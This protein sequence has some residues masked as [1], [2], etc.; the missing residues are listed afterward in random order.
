MSEVKVPPRCPEP[1]RGFQRAPSAEE[2]GTPAVEGSCP[3][4][5]PRSCPVP[6][7][8][9]QDDRSVICN[10]LQDFSSE[11]QPETINQAQLNNYYGYFQPQERDELPHPSPGSVTVRICPTPYCE[12]IRLPCFKARPRPCTWKL[13]GTAAVS[14]ALEWPSGPGSLTGSFSHCFS[15]IWMQTRAPGWWFGLCSLLLSAILSVFLFM[16]LLLNS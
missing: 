12:P 9:S 6:V 3:C 8:V 4:E 14:S 15:R 10:I 11:Q 16:S 7:G 2:V 13:P 5:V 1:G